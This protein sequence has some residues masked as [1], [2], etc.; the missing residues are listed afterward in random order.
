MRSAVGFDTKRGDQVEVVNLRF[1]EAQAQIINEPTGVMSFL[2]FTKDDIVRGVEMLVMLLLGLVVVLMVVRPLVRRIITPDEAALAAKPPQLSR[3]SNLRTASRRR[4]SRC[5]DTIAL[6][7]QSGATSRMIDIAQVKGQVHAQS[8]Q[9][10]GELADQNPNEADLDHP[11][12][13]RR[14]RTR[15]IDPWQL[16]HQKPATD[17]A[18]KSRKCDGDARQPHPGETESHH[19]LFRSQARRHA[20]ARAGRGIRRQDL[21]HAG[22]RRSP[23]RFPS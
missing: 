22:R 4:K 16:Q 1:A 20:D 10:V 9:K 7:D 8:V 19:E 3:P 21:E 13:A 23:A 2:T 12:V 17:G 6:P 18:R 14:A 5:A 15:V 11:P